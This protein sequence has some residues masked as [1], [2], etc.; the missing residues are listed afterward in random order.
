MK[1][2]NTVENKIDIHKEKIVP[3]VTAGIS[4]F[5]IMYDNELIT[6]PINFSV[7]A[8]T[9]NNR[10]V[11]MSRLVS[12]VQKYSSGE[13][14]EDSMNKIMKEVNKTQ[15]KCKVISEFEYP[16]E[17]QFMRI[18]IIIQD[19]K[20]IEYDFTRTGITSCP[21]SKEISGIGHMQ[22]TILTVKITTNKKLDFDEIASRMNECFST[23]PK[24]FLNRAKESEKIL[25]AQENSMFVEDVIR[26]TLKNFPEAK[27][28]KAKSLE[29]IHTHNAISSWKKE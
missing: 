12:S 8:S 3:D 22:R 16:Y 17:D 23:I 28:I 14:I 21:C 4:D 15:N 24:E 13:T 10:G 20:N 26:E 29:S 7:T 5:K 27:S 6:I 9:S 19:N 18:R 1:N 25:I 2:K 11:H